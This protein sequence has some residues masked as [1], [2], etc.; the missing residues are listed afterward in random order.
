MIVKVTHVMEIEVLEPLTDESVENAYF[1]HMI[2]NTSYNDREIEFK[3]EI[4]KE[5]SK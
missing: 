4:I 3:W 2:G 1:G 5:E